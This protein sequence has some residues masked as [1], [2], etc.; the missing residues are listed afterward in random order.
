MLTYPKFPKVNV[1]V[2]QIALGGGLDLTSPP[3]IA[4]PGTVRF[5]LNYEAEIDGGYLRLGGFERFDGRPAPHEAEYTLLKAEAGFTGVVVGNTL[6]GATSGATG[7]VIYITDTLVGLTRTSVAVFA[8]EVV[9]VAAVPVGTVTNTEPEIDGFLD[10][11]LA[12]LAANEWRGDI[13]KPAGSGAIA[14]VAV[15]NDVVYCWRGDSGNLVTYK[16]TAAGWVVVPLFDT[17]SFT[18]GSAAY[19]DGDTLTQGGASATI[20]RVV[21]ESGDWGAGTA[22]GRLII[23]IIAGTFAAGAAVGGGAAN[24]T[25]AATSITM[26]S[27]GRVKS[28][29]HSFTASLASRRLY[30]CD[31]VNAEWE[32]DGTVLVPISTGMGSVRA[33]DVIV[34]KQHLFYSYRTSLQ[35]SS[36]AA[37]YQWSAVTGAAELGVGDT[38]TNLIAVSGT[39][40]AAALMVTCVNSAFVLYGSAASGDDAWRLVRISNE[41]GAQAGS[42]QEIGGVI[43][44]DV[45][46]FNNFSPTDTFGNFSYESASFKINPLVRGAIVKCSVLQKAGS[47][48]RC[49][50]SD[51]LF[52][53]GTPSGKGMAWM[54]CDYGRVIECAVAGEI[55]G[56]WRVFLGDADGWVIE[57]DVGRSFD[58]EEVLAFM[59][60]SSVDQ[61]SSVTL[62]TYR[63]VVVEVN[64][65]SAGILSVTAEYN[66]DITANSN[67]LQ[68]QQMLGRG[69]VY[70]RNLYSQA[71]YAVRDTQDPRYSVRGIGKSVSILIQ[72]ES[73]DAMPYRLMR[74]VLTFSPRRLAR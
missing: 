48:Y 13:Q 2:Q 3:G 36:I 18:G 30:C 23:D 21:L 60:L 69:A 10:N 25:G 70:S 52:V 65:E 66:G 72:S 40:A 41:A 35:H 61:G 47:K 16:S 29:V 67:N 9:T 26:A 24:L 71:Y 39:E 43:G 22:V 5:S 31:G 53:T 74:L 44:F 56:E 45:E 62:K 28:V 58:G 8:E 49:F 55:N 14:G 15:L 73:S 12:E 54:S 42:I 19:E 46:G 63:D 32:F 7:E 11:E 34:H 1:Q 37:P 57:A 17:V 51:G 68:D 38:I 20:K 33:S 50:F 4:K 27:G 59:R 6:T 64:P